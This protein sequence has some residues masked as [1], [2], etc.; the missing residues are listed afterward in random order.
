MYGS[1]QRIPPR[2]PSIARMRVLVV[3]DHV[4]YLGLVSSWLSMLG[5]IVAVETATSGAQALV[6]MDSV[7]PELVLTDVEMPEMSGFEFTRLVK[8]RQAPPTVVMMTGL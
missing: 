2:T 4:V 7:R 1:A 3:D 5:G 8:A 6:L